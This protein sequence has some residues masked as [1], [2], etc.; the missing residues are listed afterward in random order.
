MAGSLIKINPILAGEDGV[1]AP[2]S[3]AR[4][5]DHVLPP[6]Q[7]D[8]AFRGLQPALRSGAFLLLWQKTF[9]AEPLPDP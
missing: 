7:F 1:V 4:G 3:R 2:L 9:A 6:T 8:A 5:E